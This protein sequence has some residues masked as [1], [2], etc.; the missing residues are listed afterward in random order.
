MNTMIF[1]VTFLSIV[2]LYNI[3]SIAKWFKTKNDEVF[4]TKFVIQKPGEYDLKSNYSYVFDLPIDDR[5][6]IT[7][8]SIPLTLRLPE[9]PKNGDVIELIDQPD[10]YGWGNLVYKTDLNPRLNSIQGHCEDGDLFPYRGGR[11]ILT[12]SERDNFWKCKGERGV[13]NDP[14]SGWY[15]LSFKG[16]GIG[17]GFGQRAATSLSSYMRID[18]T[19]NPLLLTFYGG[20]PSY[21]LNIIIGGK[22]AIWDNKSNRLTYPDFPHYLQSTMNQSVPVFEQQ[23]DGIIFDYMNGGGWLKDDKLKIWDI[24]SNL[25]NIN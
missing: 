7:E 13:P 4:K 3:S 9:D 21:P 8:S 6:I 22:S 15:T 23:K 10:R 17:Q 11:V 1:A 14:W 5:Y 24:P 2:I 18:G 25:Q 16:A 20:S 19:Q 12:W